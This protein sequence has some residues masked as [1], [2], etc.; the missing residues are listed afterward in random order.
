M[1]VSEFQRRLHGAKYPSNDLKYFPLWVRRYSQSVTEEDGRLRVSV[2]SVKA[3]SRALLEMKT[4]AWQRLQAVR[5]VEAYRDL[6]LGTGEPPLGD[7]RQVL[8]RLVAEELA[9]AAGGAAGASR[10]GVDDERH[11]VGVIDPQEP[12]VLQEMRRELRVRRK[13]LET[14]RAY[15]GWVSRFIRHCHSDDLRQF[16]DGETTPAFYSHPKSSAF[17]R[18]HQ[19]RPTLR[20]RDSSGVP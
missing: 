2:A 20:P 13:A 18:F 7:I 14:E 1:S 4:P 8:Q 11:L 10:P 3:F 19:P 16:G 17:R 5:A 12:L 9:D 6:V 15:V